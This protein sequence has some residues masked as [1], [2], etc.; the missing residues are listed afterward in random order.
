MGASRAAWVAEPAWR[1]TLRSIRRRLRT[2]R[3]APRR[4]LPIDL[5][6][7]MS[8]AFIAVAGAVALWMSFHP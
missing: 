4:H 1:A 3:V 5:D 6:T 7:L 8:Q 2:R